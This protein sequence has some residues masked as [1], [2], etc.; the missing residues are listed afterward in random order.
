MVKG[1]IISIIICS[2]FIFGCAGKP[3]TE[4]IYKPVEIKIPVMVTPEI[5]RIPKPHLEIYDLSRNST[6]KEVI[7]AYYNS[8]KK[9]IIYSNKL[10]ETLKPFIKK[11]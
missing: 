10:E 6:D 4:Y 7:E 9:M 3:K 2:F 5:K 8:L 1:K 11:E